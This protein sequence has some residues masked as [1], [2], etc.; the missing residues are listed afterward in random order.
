M[1]VTFSSREKP[2]KPVTDACLGKAGDAEAVVKNQRL[3]DD[4]LVVYHL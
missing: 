2:V 3:S 4:P 1:E